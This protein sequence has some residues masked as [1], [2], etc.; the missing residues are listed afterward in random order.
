MSYL[1]I[2]DHG[3]I[4]DMHTVALVG[5]DGTIDWCCLPHFDSPSVFA[6]ILD[7]QKGGCFKLF[8]TSS[9]KQRQMYHPDTNIL[10]TRSYTADGV[11][12]IEDFM[13][14]ASTGED[15]KLHQI[16]RHVSCVRGEMQY[17]L[18]CIPAFDYA[19][20]THSITIKEQGAIFNTNGE[21]IFC[22]SSPIP[23]SVDGAS[24]KATFTL[25]EGESVS[26]VFFTISK[27]KGGD[28]F[29]RIK[30]PTKQLERTIRFWQ[31]WISR[32][33]YKGRWSEMVYRS[34]LT[35]KLLT[36][37]PTGAIVAAP[38]M[39]LPEQ[40]GGER[41]W[42]YRYT[43][44][45]D[46]SFTLYALM[47]I[48]YTDEAA[49]FMNWL[50]A[51]CQEID[52]KNESPLYI[53]YGINGNNK[54]EE[55][56]LS[57]LSGYQNSSPVRLG[58]AAYDQLQLDIYGELMDSVYLY[59]KYGSPITYND[60]SNMRRLIDWLADNWDQADEGIWETRGG[61]QHFVY[62][63]LMSWV[64]LDRASRMSM[65]SSLPGDRIKWT[66][67]RDKIYDQI[68]TRGW[69]PK[70]RCFVQHFDTTA[71][72]ASNLLMPL[73]KFI[74]PSDP[75]MRST[76]DRTLE[77]LTAD[78]LV[79]RYNPE[80]SPDGLLGDEGTFSICT[81][82]LVEC[83]TRAGRLDQ[84]RLIFQKMIGYAN[85][86]GLY[87]EEIG[88]HG[89]MLGNFPQAFT[90]LSLISAAYNLDRALSSRN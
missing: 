12:Q 78:S 84:A 57:H 17:S 21:G 74:S 19:R 77:T 64:A 82:W 81:F 48:G 88:H 22:L 53:M 79:Y 13:P 47:R 61:R 14:I 56:V 28:P 8:S 44:I 75:R 46:A 7:H 15:K 2:E 51:R 49:Q 70:Q 40:I 1:P 33:S 4:G 55:T 27:A 59:N 3:I 67:Q 35:L 76:I 42:D 50:N 54:L 10:V 45:R 34:A 5:I 73:V 43:W 83:L 52:Y 60:W 89:E 68:M 69:D 24:V 16:I 11:G 39:G 85:H 26:F 71:L 58:N 36:F 25:K 86:L 62:S 63:R 80:E 6:S 66:E 87:S 23:L 38:T 65:K 29:S 30:S 9:E 20:G 32:C 31:N 41:N 37:E 72:D 90:H 18:E